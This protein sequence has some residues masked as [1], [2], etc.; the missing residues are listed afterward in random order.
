[1]MLMLQSLRHVVCV[2]VCEV[3]SWLVHWLSVRS[4]RQTEN[5]EL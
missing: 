3:G 2:C 4:K 1:M 5:Q